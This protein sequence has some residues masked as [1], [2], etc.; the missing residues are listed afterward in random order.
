MKHLNG[1]ETQLVKDSIRRTPQGLAFTVRCCDDHE[2]SVHIQNAHQFAG[3]LNALK[4]EILRHQREVSE[5]HAAHLLV[6]EFLKEECVQSGKD[7]E[8]S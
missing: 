1:H 5:Q 8:C 2:H 4:R 7:C 6:E 3:D